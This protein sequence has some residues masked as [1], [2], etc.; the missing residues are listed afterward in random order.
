[1]YPL[2]IC[3]KMSRQWFESLHRWCMSIILQEQRTKSL[4]GNRTIGPSIETA[5]HSFDFT[6]ASANLG[7][8]GLS[9]WVLTNNWMTL[10]IRALQFMP[11]QI[12]LM[13][14]YMRIDIFQNKYCSSNLCK[15]SAKISGIIG[16]FLNESHFLS[17]IR[18]LT[19]IHSLPLILTHSPT[20]TLTL[21]LIFT[22]ALS[23]SQSLSLTHSPSLTDFPSLTLSLSYSHI[24]S[25]TSLL[26]SL[27]HTS[28]LP[29][30]KRDLFCYQRFETSV[31]KP[32]PPMI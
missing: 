24:F 25:N 2:P 29:M 28:S 15:W 8:G 18:T 23:H 21:T 3:V 22:L 11:I 13:C 12:D 9:L 30:T 31:F 6:S 17:L 5:M 4:N 27:F 26:F 7:V 14:I 16:L 20:L 1:M 32:P 10:L 19:M